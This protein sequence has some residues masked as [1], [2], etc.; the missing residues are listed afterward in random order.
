[1]TF[2][3]R[4]SISNTNTYHLHCMETLKES[5]DYLNAELTKNKVFKEKYY[6]QYILGHEVYLTHQ[7][8]LELFKANKI[9]NLLN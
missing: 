5:N 8:T 3:K 1:M 4:E 9:G 2:S 7:E 6:D